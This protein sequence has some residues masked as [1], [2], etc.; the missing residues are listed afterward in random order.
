M[1]NLGLTSLHLFLLNKIVQ[2]KS[3]NCYDKV[4]FI[5]E[6]QE[7]GYRYTIYYS[8]FSDL[9]EMNEKKYKEIQIEACPYPLMISSSQF[10]IKNKFN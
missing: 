4:K 6:P 7:W 8:K 5:E 10:T 9:L 3:L 2:E 1:L